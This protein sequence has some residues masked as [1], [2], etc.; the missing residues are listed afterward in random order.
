MFT[1][2]D[3]VSVEKINT[4]ILNQR[5]ESAKCYRPKEWSDNLLRCELKLRP[6]EILKKN[7]F[8]NEISALLLSEVRDN[9]FNTIKYTNCFIDKETGKLEIDVIAT[10]KN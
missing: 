3:N 6:E 10:I 2:P 4:Y 9:T 1:E 8:C 7:N 5:R